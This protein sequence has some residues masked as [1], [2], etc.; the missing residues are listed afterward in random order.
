MFNIFVEMDFNVLKGAMPLEWRRFGTGMLRRLLSVQ[1]EFVDEKGM[2][3]QQLFRHFAVPSMTMVDTY[4]LPRKGEEMR[5][6]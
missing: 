2:R 6:T 3:F 5:R 4:R 1:M